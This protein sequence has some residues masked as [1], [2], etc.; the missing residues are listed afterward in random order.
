M[1]PANAYTIRSATDEDAH[2]LQ[3]LAELDSRAAPTGRILIAEDEGIRARTRVTGTAP[4]DGSR[5][6]RRATRRTL[7]RG[8]SP[9]E[10][11]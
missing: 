2:T 9:L 6:T 3:L 5:L 11:R 10:R 4:A 8:C 1:Y 7:S